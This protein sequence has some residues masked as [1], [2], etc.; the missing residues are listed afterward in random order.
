MKKRLLSAA[1]CAGIL[2]T[3]SGCLKDTCR[4]TY[5]IYA[6]IT[7]TLTQVRAEMRSAA[8]QPLEN[9]GKIY[10]FG[11]Y[12]FMNEVNKGIHIIDNSNPASPQNISFIN[13]PNNIDLAVK[14]NYLYADSYSDIAV[15]DISNPTNV[16]AVKFLN[17]VIRDKNRYW[18]ANQT[19][20]DQI[21]VIVGYSERDTTVDCETYQSWTGCPNCVFATAGGGGVFSA[22]MPQAGAGGSMARFAIQNDFLYAVSTNELYSISISDPV[23]PLL[24][25]TQNLGSWV[26]ET[27][28]PFRDKLFIGSRNGMFIYTLNNP[29]VPT[30]QG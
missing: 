22:S 26:V 29:A 10:V 14:G 16:T 30:A 19:N 27:I 3:L 15:F 6:P 23:S 20:P 12:I 24:T 13:I 1:V 21:N 17:N 18:T 8:P 28:Y 25:S 9:T 11:N 7:K 4:N 2:A 5:K